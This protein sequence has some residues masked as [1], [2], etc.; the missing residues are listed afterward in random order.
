MIWTATIRPRLVSIRSTRDPRTTPHGFRTIVPGD[1]VLQNVHSTSPIPPPLHTC[2]ESR[3]ALIKS[4]YELAFKL[5][6]KRSLSQPRVW[7]N[8]DCDTLYLALPEAH[9]NFG[10]LLWYKE[11]LNCNDWEGT[12]RVERL[13][14]LSPIHWDTLRYYRS[15]IDV[16]QNLE[17]L[18][19]VKQH[20]SM[21]MINIHGSMCDRR[22]DPWEFLEYDVMA[23]ILGHNTSS[24]SHIWM[25]N[26][27]NYKETTN[28]NGLHY[29]HDLAKDLEQMIREERKTW[30]TGSMISVVENVVVKIGPK[31][32]FKV[33]RVIYGSVVTSSMA[34][35]IIR[36][37]EKYWE[38]VQ[39]KEVWEAVF[40][41][42]LQHVDKDLYELGLIDDD[43]YMR[44]MENEA[45]VF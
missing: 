6:I 39:E 21:R 32:P 5:K 9:E 3:Q 35:E 30:W 7:F 23:D 18:L 15:C 36:R 17:N 28:S 4:G 14:M 22:R 29:F 37:R 41:H 16:F 10:D 26:V 12:D 20:C 8:F 31:R 42:P 2:R 25:Q 43:E 40:G 13:A 44:E 27:Q 33:P 34:D 19:L 1:T 24:T 11:Y 38:A 45:E